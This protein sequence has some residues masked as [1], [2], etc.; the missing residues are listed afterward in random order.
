M[1]GIEEC[2]DIE[3]ARCKF[4]LALFER[5]NLYEDSVKIKPWYWALRVGDKTVAFLLSKGYIESH[6]YE[7][8]LILAKSEFN[9]ETLNKVDSLTC[10]FDCPSP[11]MYCTSRCGSELFTSLSNMARNLYLKGDFGCL[12]GAG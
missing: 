7:H 3:S 11:R 9:L 1:S 5:N 4:R 10:S 6:P 12:R 8:T 2:I